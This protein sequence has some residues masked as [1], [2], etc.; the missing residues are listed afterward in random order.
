[1]FYCVCGC[2]NDISG[3]GEIGGLVGYVMVD[4]LHLPD[5]LYVLVTI[6]LFFGKI[7]AVLWAFMW[8]QVDIPAVQI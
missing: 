4:K 2:G 7:L 5:A 6:L 3:G 8:F 1:M